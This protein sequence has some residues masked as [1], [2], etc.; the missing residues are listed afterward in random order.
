MSSNSDFTC[1]DSPEELGRIEG[2]PAPQEPPAL[3]RNAAIQ[4]R[5]FYVALTSAGFSTMEAMDLV[6]V[7]IETAAKAGLDASNE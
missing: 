3:W 4:A 2:A 1:P 5:Q 7:V 6:K